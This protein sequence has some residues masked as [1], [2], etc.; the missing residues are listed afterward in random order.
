M[1]GGGAGLTDGEKKPGLV[2]CMAD[3][4]PAVGWGR[5][6]HGH[7]VAEKCYSKIPTYVTNN[8]VFLYLL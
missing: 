2:R 4:R 6:C 8:N 3:P 1:R 5:R 7:P